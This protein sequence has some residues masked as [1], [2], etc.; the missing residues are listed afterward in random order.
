MILLVFGFTIIEVG[1][2][3]IRRGAVQTAISLQD[4]RTYLED[5]LG[6]FA[7]AMEVVN[8]LPEDSRVIMLWEPRNLYC[9]PKCE[10]DEILDRWVVER[11]GDGL[12]VPRSPETILGSW[13][14]SGYTYLLFYNAGAEFIQN[15]GGPL[16]KDDWS[17]L[18]SI[19]DE[20][21]VYQGFGQAY[22]LYTL[23][24]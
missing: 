13:K 15:E 16:S 5:N 2:D 19:L 23:E 14:E 1:V 12:D 11:Y 20:L 22:T 9:L 10:P 3:T 17:A 4:Q 18:D 7:P 21:P 6:W 8:T 24:P